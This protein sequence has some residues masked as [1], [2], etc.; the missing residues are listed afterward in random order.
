MF[1]NKGQSSSVF[2]LLIAAL[3]SLAI[4]G[5]LLGIMGGIDFSPGQN[6]TESVKKM[7]QNASNNVFSPF[8]EVIT[9]S[10]KYSTVPR[11]A[12]IAKTDVGEDLQFF[13]CLENNESTTGLDVQE[14][15]VKYNGTSSA[16]YNA[17]AVCGENIN[18]VESNLPDNCSPP[19]SGYD[20]FVVF[21]DYKG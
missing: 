11:Q 15:F 8:T 14:G 13:S 3:V 7:V 18:P 9:F 1:D 17:T 20:C 10:K 6:P 21:W 19:I 2:N 12:I 5:V 4:L 16:K